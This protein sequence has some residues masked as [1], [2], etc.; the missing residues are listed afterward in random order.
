MPATEKFYH[1][2]MRLRVKNAAKLIS[3]SYNMFRTISS[4]VY[5][6]HNSMI[7]FYA[8]YSTK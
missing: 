6:Y 5:Q 4:S 8:K 2:I 7:S 3:K 1:K